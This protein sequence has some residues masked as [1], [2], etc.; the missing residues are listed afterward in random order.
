M[1]YF[2][3]DAFTDKN[4]KGNPAGICLLEN[5]LDAVT[6]QNI[7]AENNLS[8]TAFV[9]KQNGYYDLRW[10]TPKNEIDLCGHATL[11]SAF[12]I[13]TFFDA[14][15][16]KVRFETKSGVLFVEKENDLYSL[17]FPSSKPQKTAVTEKMERAI[18]VTV[19]EA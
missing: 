3:V 5:D 18:G 6:M 19:L 17:D 12:I 15:A 10:F 13:M 16:N 14:T 2:V 1:K 11:G 4:F 9:L 7:A 8:E